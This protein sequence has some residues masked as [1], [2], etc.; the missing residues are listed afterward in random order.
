MG[1]DI[2]GFIVQAALLRLGDKHLSSL[3]FA[4]SGIDYVFDDADDLDVGFRVHG[5][6]SYMPANRAVSGKVLLGEH[7]IDDADTSRFSCIAPVK[8]P[9]CQQGNS[10]RWEKAR[11][12]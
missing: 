4:R 8:V 11:R 12:D 9:A 2:A 6:E 3:A 7:P 1:S 10:H 5:D